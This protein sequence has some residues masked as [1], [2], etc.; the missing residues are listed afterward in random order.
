[1]SVKIE[2]FILATKGFDEVIDITSKVNDIVSYVSSK[3]GLVN[4]FVQSS[5]AS[6]LILE[7]EPALSSDLAKLLENIVP[8]NKI[9]QHDNTW[10]DGNAYAHLKSI[11][12]GNSLTLPVHDSK[13]ALGLYQQI[14]LLDFDNK[15]SEKEIIISV[16]S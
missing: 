13:V 6:I 15:A 11:L 8:I 1:M 5:T 9:Y 4:I 10:H 2:K 14:V 3:E 7:D 16:V 12:L